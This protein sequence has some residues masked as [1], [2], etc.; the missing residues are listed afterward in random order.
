MSYCDHTL[1]VVRPS[2]IS[3]I[4]DLFSETA[5]QISTKLDGNQ[6]LNVLC[7]VCDFRAN[8]SKKT[9]A[10][11]F[12]QDHRGNMQKAR[13]RKQKQDARNNM[14]EACHIKP[15]PFHYGIARRVS[16]GASPAHTQHSQ[17]YLYTLMYVNYINQYIHELS[18][19][20]FY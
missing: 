9:A 7:Q 11:T 15:T 13:C 8:P 3:H 6:V 14:H 16:C 1:S 19:S 4:F 17:I 20:I 12:K 10:L 5:K 2:L 18:A